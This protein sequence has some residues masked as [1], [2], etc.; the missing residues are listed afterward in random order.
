MK[1]IYVSYC[2]FA[3]V[4]IA[5]LLDRMIIGTDVLGP[6][7]TYAIPTIDVGLA[8]AVCGYVLLSLAWLGYSRERREGM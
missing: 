1:F 4:Q 8:L 5:R 3:M 2:A 6:F 7:Y